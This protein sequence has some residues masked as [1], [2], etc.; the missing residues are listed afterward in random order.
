MQQSYNLEQDVAQ[1]RPKEYIRNYVT[2]QKTSFTSRCQGA[3]RLS[4]HRDVAI[5]TNDCRVKYAFVHSTSF[6]LE[7]VYVRIIGLL[8]LTRGG[9]TTFGVNT[10]QRYPMFLPPQL[11]LVLVPTCLPNTLRGHLSHFLHF[12]L[13][14]C[15]LTLADKYQ[16]SK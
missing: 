1:V 9:N 8:L 12:S 13:W 10:G 11:L 7:D 2:I 5:E 6:D 16:A 15:L 4:E 3:C 14:S